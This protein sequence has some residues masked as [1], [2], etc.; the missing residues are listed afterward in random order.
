M[1]CRNT[2]SSPSAMIIPAAPAQ[3]CDRVRRD[4]RFAQQHIALILGGGCNAEAFFANLK[5]RTY[6]QFHQVSEAHLHRYL[7]EADFKWDTRAALGYDD[8]ERV[9]PSKARRRTRFFSG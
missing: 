2:V 7:A 3:N 5:C 9:A 6:G 4:D 8:V 1:P